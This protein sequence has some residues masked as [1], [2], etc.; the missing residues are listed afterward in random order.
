MGRYVIYSADIKKYAVVDFTWADSMR[1]ATQFSTR[2][3][4][5]NF[6][7][8]NLARNPAWAHMVSGC[9]VLTSSQGTALE[10]RKGGSISGDAVADSAF[11]SVSTM[12]DQ[13][14]GIARQ[15]RALQSYYAGQLSLMDL[16]LED[17]LHEAEFATLNVVEGYKLYRQIHDARQKRRKYKDC[18]ETIQT[19]ESCHALEALTQLPVAMQKKRDRFETRSYTPRMVH[20]LFEN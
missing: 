18:L 11:E 15:I 14:G 1:D 19:I 3:A 17:L 2:K 12:I 7:H 4:A 6:L 16:Q 5:T 9:T 13:M 8:R 20:G 10:N